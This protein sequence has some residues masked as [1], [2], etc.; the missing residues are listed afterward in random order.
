MHARTRALQVEKVITSFQPFADVWHLIGAVGPFVTSIARTP[1]TT[2]K[3]DEISAE[4]ASMKSRYV[5]IY[6]C[7][8]SATNRT[9]LTGVLSVLVQVCYYRLGIVYITAVN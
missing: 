5:C 9:T 4:H 8:N 1:V 7:D 3:P 2:L 6:L